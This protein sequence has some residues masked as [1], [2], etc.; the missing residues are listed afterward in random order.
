MINIKNLEFGADTVPEFKEVITKNEIIIRWGEDNMF[1]EELYFLLNASPIHYSSISA[2]VI[3]SV[4][5]GYINDYKIN[6]KQYLNDVIRQM[7]FEYFVTGNLFLEII[8]KKDRKEG[9]AG[10]HVIPSKYIRIGKPK[11]EGALPTK[12][13]YSKNWAN[14]RRNSKVVEFNEFDPNNYTNRQ[15]VHIKQYNGFS[16][17][18]GTPS[19][20]SVL[21]DVKLNHEITLFNLS[22]I[23]NG[24]S[25]GLWI[26]FNS[27]APDSEMEQTQILRKIEDRYMGAKNA[28][29]VIVSYG[30]DGS[31]KPEITQ[32]QRSVEDGY[33]TNI[34][35]LVQFQIL[36]GHGIP[37][38][39]IIGL[40]SRT[41]F[42][43][44]AEQLETA[45]NL[46]MSRTI[47]PTQNFMTRE[48]KQ[49]LELMY[50]NEE[51]NLVIEQKQLLS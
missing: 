27:E 50:P 3:N 5:S 23:Q 21:N 37:D 7:Y 20:L 24:L 22:N 47:I 33:F 41:G 26:H 19:Y 8:W 39:S 4:G 14:Y 42:S 9:I 12:Y 43:S 25:P 29:R 30:E 48:L 11:E 15:I 16:E 34:F 46:F 1:V 45:N 49:I 32:M 17:Y 31:G 35:E 18:Y 13:Y 6:S 51:I 38:P 44:S 28:N 40:P 36:S 2:K 10:F